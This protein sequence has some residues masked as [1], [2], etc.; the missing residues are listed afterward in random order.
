MAGAWPLPL[1]AGAAL[2]AGALAILTRAMVVPQSRLLIPVLTRAADRTTP[3]VALTFD[4]GPWPGSTDVIL[5]LLKAATISAAF[6]VIGRNVE[7]W[8][9]LVQRMHDEGHIVGNHSFDHHRLGSLCG[10]S[11][12]RDQIRLTDDAVHS[13][14]GR[15]PA[16]FR[17]PMGIKTPPLAAALKE[18]GHTAIAWSRRG[19]DGMAASPGAIV[20]KIGTRVREGEIVLLHD[21]RDA[22]SKRDVRATSAAL[23]EIIRLTHTRG[24]Q[25]ASLSAM[26]PIEPYFARATG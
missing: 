24:L 11:Y 21:G 15:R 19:F 6:F 1:I 8:P 3:R 13:V 20:R 10:R 2:S 17:P 18:T 5:D 7:R 14:I 9:T 22:R 26:L 16:L 12:W 23:P 4:D 25:F